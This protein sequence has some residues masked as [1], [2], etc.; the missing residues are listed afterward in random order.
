M[1]P[2]QAKTQQIGQLLKGTAL[3]ARDLIVVKIEACEIGEAMEDSRVNGYERITVEIKELQITQSIEGTGRYN[4][5]LP[6]L[7]PER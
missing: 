5:D 1:V 6:P 7:D 4:R 3:D 2:V